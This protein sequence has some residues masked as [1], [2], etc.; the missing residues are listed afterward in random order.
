[1]SSEAVRLLRRKGVVGKLKGATL[2]AHW[3][4]VL[5]RFLCMLM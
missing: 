1:M 4:G 5:L 3:A 2:R